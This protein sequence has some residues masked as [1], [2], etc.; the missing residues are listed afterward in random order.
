MNKKEKYSYLL[1]EIIATAKLE[2]GKTFTYKFDEEANEL[3]PQRQLEKMCGTLSEKFPDIFEMISNASPSMYIWEIHDVGCHIKRDIRQLEKIKSEMGV[4]LA[5]QDENIKRD[6]ILI[7]EAD[8]TTDYALWVKGNRE[9]VYNMKKKTDG[10][11]LPS[12]KRMFGLISNLG[13]VQIKREDKNNIVTGFIKNLGI[14][15]SEAESFFFRRD[16]KWGI[17]KEHIEVIPR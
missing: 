8:I 4:L 6:K 1:E 11:F 3:L 5:E 12:G 13:T 14:S 17:K 2:Q 15:K 16:G 10:E 7:L 9:Q